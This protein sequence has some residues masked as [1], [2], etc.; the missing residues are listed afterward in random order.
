MKQSSNFLGS[1]LLL[2]LVGLGRQESSIDVRND[3]TL[4][5]DNV[6][7]EL[8]QPVATRLALD[9]DTTWNYALLI[10]ADSELEVTGDNTLLLVVASGVTSKLEDLSGEV[11][12]DGRQVDCR[13]PHCQPRDSELHRLFHAPGAPA[14]TR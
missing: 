8:V 11:L 9:H 6:T 12:E 10:V 5:D 4:A 14:P 13:R 3:T 2:A 1:G 7:E